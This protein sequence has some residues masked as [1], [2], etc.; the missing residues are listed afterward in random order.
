[1]N[2]LLRILTIATFTL[3]PIFG[4]AWSRGGMASER[5]WAPNGCLHEVFVDDGS[6][7]RH[8]FSVYARDIKLTN[9]GRIA[10]IE[11]FDDGG[12]R[13]FVWNGRGFV[14]KGKS[15]KQR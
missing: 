6:R 3:S 4:Q 9:D 10:G 5:P 13:W 14:A 1:M 11:V 7:Q 15:R 2:P 8:V 12:V